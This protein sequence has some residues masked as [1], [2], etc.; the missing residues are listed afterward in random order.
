MSP[1]RPRTGLNSSLAREQTRASSLA[2]RLTRRARGQRFSENVPENA[3][4]DGQF[5]PRRL[6]VGLLILRR[7]DN[8]N[9]PSP[10]QLKNAG[11]C[12]LI[13]PLAKVSLALDPG[14]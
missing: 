3:K 5:L 7:L 2:L 14:R 6:V 13:R 8:T 11:F 1:L 12:H 4:A 9:L 10:L